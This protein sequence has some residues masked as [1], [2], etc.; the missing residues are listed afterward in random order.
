MTDP[1]KQMWQLAHKVM[2][3]R[4]Y[5]VVLLHYRDGFSHR[6]IARMLGISRQAVRERIDKGIGRLSA[7]T[8]HERKAA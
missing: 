5:E 6:A 8:A 2:T 4:Q 3:D 1:E 7:A